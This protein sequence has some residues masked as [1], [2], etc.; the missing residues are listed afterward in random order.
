MEMWTVC[1]D[2]NSY[3]FFGSK[4]TA[5]IW[6]KTEFPVAY[7]QNRYHINEFVSVSQ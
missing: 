3:G 7:A 6:V 5:H 2:G 1:V 4:D